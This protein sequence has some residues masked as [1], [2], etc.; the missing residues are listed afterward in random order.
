[1]CNVCNPGS[2]Q[3][4]S[5]PVSASTKA[6]IRPSGKFR[7][8]YQSLQACWVLARGS[9]G[10]LSISPSARE[11]RLIAQQRAVLHLQEC[12]AHPQPQIT[13]KAGR[14]TKEVVVI[15]LMD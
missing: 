8:L 4:S 5:R 6:N 1:M 2:L 3:T 10:G 13:T 11:A 9:V 7:G 14:F 15:L 12:L